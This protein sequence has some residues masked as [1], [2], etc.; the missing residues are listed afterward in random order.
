M[1]WHINEVTDALK[2]TTDI[3]S[4]EKQKSSPPKAEW[5][6]SFWI[7]REVVDE[8]IASAREPVSTPP[9]AG[10]Q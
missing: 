10:L 8:L 2:R 6:S 7:N 9:V 1:S 3:Q 4:M 5:N